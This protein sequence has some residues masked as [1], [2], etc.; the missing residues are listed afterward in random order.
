MIIERSVIQG[1]PEWMA[2]RVANPGVSNFD[3]IITSTGKASTQRQKYLF[4]LAGEALIG[5]K[6]ESYN[7][8]AMTRGT[9]LEPKAR[10]LFEFTKGLK[11]EEVGMCYPDEL[12]RYH[13]SPD[14]IMDEDKKGLEI[15]CPLL[16]THVEYLSGG[17]LPTKY[18][19]QVQGSLMVTDYNSWYFMSFYPG[20][21]PL[22][23]EVE[24]DE[25][26]ISIMKE[27]VEEFCFDLA[28][29]VKKLS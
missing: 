20:I 1:E 13:A 10:K 28:E 12:K 17:K 5:A 21:K 6:E 9:E 3:K 14:G 24:R 4:Q 23:V 27:A 29:L 18:K 7:N 16:A 2:L 8:A 26:L 19:C 22:I 11:V 25:K 15:K